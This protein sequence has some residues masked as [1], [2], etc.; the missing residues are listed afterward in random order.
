M[1]DLFNLNFLR[2]LRPLLLHFTSG[3]LLSVIFYRQKEKQGGSGKA[4]LMGCGIAIC[5][6]RHLDTYK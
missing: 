6:S 4:D 3:F 5:H 2:G 1:V